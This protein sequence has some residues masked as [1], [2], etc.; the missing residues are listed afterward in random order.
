VYDIYVNE[1]ES[2]SVNLWYFLLFPA[3]AALAV[4]I[5][6][7]RK[8]LSEKRTRLDSLHS[9]MKDVLSAMERDQFVRAMES[10]PVFTQGML[11]MAKAQAD[12][13]DRLTR[14]VD[15][16]QSTLLPSDQQEDY[17]DNPKDF[18]HQAAEEREI[19]E[20]VRKGST[21]NDAASR[22]R[23]RDIYLQLIRNRQ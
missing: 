11:D 20:M 23:E 16:L 19:D 6:E 8:R 22:L 21:K 9:T 5:I 18:T 1:I 17:P 12:T 15:L 4:S 2:M 7:W 10:L 3:G 13:M 14:A